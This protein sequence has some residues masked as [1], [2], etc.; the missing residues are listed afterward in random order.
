MGVRKMKKIYLAPILFIFLFS[1]VS[2]PVVAGPIIQDTESGSLSIYYYQP[3]GQSFL[4]E[5]AKIKWIGAYTDPNYWPEENDLSFSVELYEG[6]GISGSS[7]FSYIFNLPSDYSG[8]ADFDVSSIT[9][10]V[11]QMYTFAF[12]NDT[13][14]WGLKMQWYTNPYLQGRS[15]HAGGGANDDLRFHVLP[16]QLQQSIYLPL[17]LKGP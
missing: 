17:I 13:R 8:Y 14:Q 6:D 10:T 5:D 9:F 4:A 12:Y 15:Y 3:V 1:F 11:G 2:A 16:M 7:I